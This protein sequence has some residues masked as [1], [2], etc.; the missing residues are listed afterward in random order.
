MII[1]HLKGIH[2]L[3]IRNVNAVLLV[4][5]MYHLRIHLPVIWDDNMEDQLDDSDDEDRGPSFFNSPAFRPGSAALQ[6]IS[7]H[8]GFKCQLCEQRLHHVCTTTKKAKVQAFYGRS[9][10]ASQVRYVEVMDAE[11]EEQDPI[12]AF[13]IPDDIHSVPNHNSSITAKRDLNQFGVKFQLYPL[14]EIVDLSELGSL[15]HTPQDKS[16]RSRYRTGW[17]ME[18]GLR[19]KLNLDD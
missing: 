12:T 15:L 8:D 4:L 1:D 5:R 13:G 10:I 7:V 14:L 19:A 6:G 2:G 16:V 9:K 11:D 18:R 17:T 3:E